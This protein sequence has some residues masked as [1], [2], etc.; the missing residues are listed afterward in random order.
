MYLYYDKYE[1]VKRP[2]KHTFVL[3]VDGC[4]YESNI[5]VTWQDMA[6]NS[7]CMFVSVFYTNIYI[8]IRIYNYY[9]VCCLCAVHPPA[10]PM[11]PVETMSPAVLW[12]HRCGCHKSETHIQSVTDLLLC[13]F[14]ISSSA[15]GHYSFC[16]KQKKGLCS[17]IV[18]PFYCCNLPKS[19][20]I[21]TKTVD[22]HF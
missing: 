10:M 6:F 12:G 15:F 13:L 3:Y 11:G 19:V 5:C 7:D 16:L 14:S 20:P 8:Y 9:Y 1:V 2:T 4:L 22:T 21:I 18:Y 17:F